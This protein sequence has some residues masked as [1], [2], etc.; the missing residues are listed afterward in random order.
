[1]RCVALAIV[2]VGVISMGLLPIEQYPD[3]T[4]PTIYVTTSYPGASSEL[5][6]GFITTPLQQ[7]IAEAQGIDYLSSTSRQGQ[8]VIEARM[9]LNYPPNDA[10]AE[11]LRRL[12][13]AKA[14]FA[15]WPTAP[16]GDTPADVPTDGP[17]DDGGGDDRR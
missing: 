7:A 13:R 9:Q 11:I 1:M 10:L 15:A 5:V 2:L 17:R 4:P 6:K 8:S 16:G 14:R 12:H 3:I